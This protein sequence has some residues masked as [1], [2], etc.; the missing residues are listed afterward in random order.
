MHIE[1]NKGNC[2]HLLTI[3]YMSGTALGQ[4]PYINQ[5]GSKAGP[6]LLMKDLHF[7]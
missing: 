4:V 7:T 1:K 6:C 2:Y 3:S 5:P